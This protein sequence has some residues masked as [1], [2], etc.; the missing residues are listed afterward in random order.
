MSKEAKLINKIT[1]KRKGARIT[2]EGCSH[3]D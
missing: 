2:I 3:Y 1:R